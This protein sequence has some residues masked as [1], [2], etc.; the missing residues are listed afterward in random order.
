MEGSRHQSR[1]R[2]HSTLK[3]IKEDIADDKR[4]YVVFYLGPINH[5]ILFIF[6][7]RL[8][9]HDNMASDTVSE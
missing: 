6:N 3:K 5:F 1:Q 2:L 9:A 4:F 8:K 7:R